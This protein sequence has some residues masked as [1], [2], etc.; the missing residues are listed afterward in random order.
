MLSKQTYHA[1]VHSDL[2]ITIWLSF[3]PLS[4]IDAVINKLNK[5]Q[6]QNA[7]ISNKYLFNACINTKKFQNFIHC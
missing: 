6:L 5:R 1:C 4:F 7:G 3:I 2:V